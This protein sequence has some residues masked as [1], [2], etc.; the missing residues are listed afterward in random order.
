MYQPVFKGPIEGW[1]V[2]YT[3]AQFWRLQ[4]TMEWDDVMQEAY[5]VFLRCSNK[6][7]ALLE[8]KHFM[9]LFKQAWIRHV[10]DLAYVDSRHRVAQ[11]PTEMAEDGYVQERVGDLDNDGQLAILMRQAPSEVRMVINLFL[12]APQEMLDSLL[13]GWTGRDRRCRNGGSLRINK[14]LGLDPKTDVLGLVEDYFRQ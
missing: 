9:A 14:A 13:S 3:K 4:A 6:Y 10:T 8:A 5:L 2:N 11:A 1:V 12:N 7:P